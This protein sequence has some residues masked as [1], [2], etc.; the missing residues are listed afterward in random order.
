MK[1]WSES[2]YRKGERN[3]FEMLRE[4]RHEREEKRTAGQKHDGM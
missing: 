3:K 2:H 1:K 4:E